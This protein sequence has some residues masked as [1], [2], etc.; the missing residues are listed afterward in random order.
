MVGAG[1]AA[2]LAGMSIGRWFV[3]GTDTDVGKTV[4]TT[5]LAA[6][7][8]R[9]GR[10]VAALKPVASGGVAPGSDATRIA[11]GAGHEPRCLRCFDAPLAPH[12]AAILEGGAPTA[13]ELLAWIASFSADVLLIEGVGGWRVPML[14]DLETRE[15]ARRC[16]D[17]VIVVAADRL[18]VI[19]HTRLTVEAIVADGLTVRGVVLNRADR[20]ADISQNTNLVDL[21]ELLGLPVVPLDAVETANQSSLAAAG[22]RLWGSL[23]V[24]G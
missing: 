11:E 23:L 7:A 13:D 17:S 20:P 24:D 4:V 10:R 14:P 5:A 3:T 21:R 22:D 15:V 8:H 2:Y 16:T 19:N 18:G 9:Q 6:S 1:T 12:R